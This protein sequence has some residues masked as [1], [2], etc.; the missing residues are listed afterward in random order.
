MISKDKLTQLEID[1]KKAETILFSILKDI[2][3]REN[4]KVSQITLYSRKIYGNTK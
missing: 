2:E 4:K 1:K 3:N